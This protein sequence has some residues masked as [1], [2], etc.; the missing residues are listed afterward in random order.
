VVII[1]FWGGEGD[2]EGG[3]KQRTRFMV[4]AFLLDAKK[5]QV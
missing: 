2:K 5:F 3:L 4:V 1:I